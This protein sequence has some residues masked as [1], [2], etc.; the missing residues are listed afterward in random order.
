[1]SS[2]IILLLVAI[3]LIVIIAY[4]VGVIIRKRNDSSIKKLEERKQSLFDLPVN[5]EVEAVKSLHLIGQSQTTFREWN[6]KWVDLSLNSFS[7]IEN[8]IFEAENFNDTF[9][10]FRARHEI[11]SVESQLNLVEEDINSIREALSILKEQEE[12]NSARVKHALDL[13]ETLQTSVTENANN[14]GTTLPEIETNLW[15]RNI[16]C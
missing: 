13:Y 9:K 6:Q 5:E 2:S 12:K 1:M 15:E 8:H 11:E 3:V 10:F 4:L 14:F 16:S 7:D